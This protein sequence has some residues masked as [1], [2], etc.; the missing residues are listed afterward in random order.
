L[1]ASRRASEASKLTVDEARN[2]A[3]STMAA[4]LSSLD[5]AGIA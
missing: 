3:A 2:E 5:S 1:G 4:I